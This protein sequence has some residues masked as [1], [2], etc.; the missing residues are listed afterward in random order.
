MSTVVQDDEDLQDPVPELLGKLLDRDGS[1]L[2][3]TAGAPDG[4]CI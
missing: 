1:D 3:L 2:H 4:R